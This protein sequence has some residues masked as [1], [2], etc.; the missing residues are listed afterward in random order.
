VTAAPVSTTSRA[1]G[2]GLPRWLVVAL[3]GLLALGA[4][5]YVAR[6][7]ITP[8]PVGNEATA[9]LGTSLPDLD[10]H[11]QSIGQWRGKVI[12]VNFWAT[13]CAPCRVEMP[14]LDAMAARRG[15]EGVVVAAV[16]YKEAPDV[17][18]RFLERAPF[19]SQI[20][21][22]A[23]GDATVHWTPRVFPTTVLVGRNGRPAQVVVGE[24]DWEGEEARAVIDPLVA[25]SGR[26]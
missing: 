22:D 10:G 8:S 3:V 25:A 24:L 20:L 13:W 5:A 4:G 6:T 11:E 7:T 14:S 23:E 16:N 26:A 1:R 15:R 12:V 17:I 9:L 21:L 18:R 19:K 2:G